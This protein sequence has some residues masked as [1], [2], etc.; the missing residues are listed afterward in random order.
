[1]EPFNPTQTDNNKYAAL[2]NQH[3]QGAEMDRYIYSDQHG[4]GIGSFFGNL[5]KSAVPILRQGIKGA[6]KVVKP[7]LKQIG[8]DLVT[9]GS[10]RLLDSISQVEHKPH[11][12]SVKPAR[13]ST[14]RRKWQG[15]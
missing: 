6:V 13:R 4:E 8:T 11:K 5:L 2:I 1:M 3:G 10:K 14:K 7:H 9:T 12:R 15:L